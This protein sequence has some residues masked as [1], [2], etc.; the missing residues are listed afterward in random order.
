MTTNG[1]VPVPHLS[2]ADDMAR[3]GCITLKAMLYAIGC[4]Q[5]LPTDQQ[6]RS[7]MIEMC[8]LVRGMESPTLAHVLWGVESHIG[9]EID[10]WPAHGGNEANGLYTDAELDAKATI[11]AQVRDWNEQFR[12]TQ[13]AKDAPPSNAVTFLTGA[14][15][16]KPEA[17]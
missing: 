15:D 1:N 9:R 2:I 16:Q 5:A 3:N 8:T 7:D 17:A 4:I 12:R 11:R 6:E 14:D 13:A 10:L